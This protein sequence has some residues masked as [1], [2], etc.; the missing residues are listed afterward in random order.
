MSVA[1]DAGD[2]YRVPPDN[3]PL[4]HEAYVSEGKIRVSRME[5]FNSQNARLLDVPE[6][7]EILAGLPFVQA[8]LS[9]AQPDAI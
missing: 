4:N 8:F 6:M 3:R 2:H 9:G 5:D 1:E 7:A